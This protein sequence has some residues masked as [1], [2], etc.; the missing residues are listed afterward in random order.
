MRSIQPRKLSSDIL[1]FLDWL[2]KT[3]R[4]FHLEYL[5]DGLEP[6]DVDEPEARIEEIAQLHEG[7]TELA[8]QLVNSKLKPLTDSKKNLQE[9]VGQISKISKEDFVNRYLTIKALS[10][11]PDQVRRWNRVKEALL[12]AKPGTKVEAY[13]W[14]AATCFLYGFFNAVAVLSRAVLE[15]ALEDALKSLGSGLPENLE[16]RI[17]FAGQARILSPELVSIAHRIRINGKDAIHKGGV[18]EAKAW[19]SLTGTLQI[20]EHIYKVVS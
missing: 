3:G 4:P 10:S 15:F 11:V 9:F 14:E 13:Y 1:S 6:F 12:G 2:N 5:K 16:S 8:G 19:E 7:V 17:K 18:G 20:L